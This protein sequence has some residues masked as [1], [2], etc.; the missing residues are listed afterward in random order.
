M[1]GL[2]AFATAVESRS[3]TRQSYH[4]PG[5]LH[6]K[7]LKTLM[8]KGKLTQSLETDAQRKC[9]RDEKQ[10][11]RG[12]M[13][14]RMAQNKSCTFSPWTTCTLLNFCDKQFKKSLFK[15]K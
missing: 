15:L 2:V 8:F 10:R 13:C 4:Q 14:S 1:E 7:A 6:T 3:V 9:L 12:W 11:E 5:S